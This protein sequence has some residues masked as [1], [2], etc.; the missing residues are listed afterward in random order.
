MKIHPREWFKMEPV[1]RFMAIWD[2]AKSNAS[3]N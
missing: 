3:K 1:D 2:K